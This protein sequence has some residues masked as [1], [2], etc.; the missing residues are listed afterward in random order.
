MNPAP[1]RVAQKRLFLIWGRERREVRSETLARHFGAKMFTISHPRLQ[2]P[3]LLPIKYLISAFQ[4]LWILLKERPRTVFVMNPPIFTGVVVWTFSLV[5]GSKFVIDTHSA[6][7]TRPA[8]RK[9]LP[10]YRFLARRASVNILHNSPLEDVV[11]SWGAKTLSLFFVPLDV[12]F[13]APFPFPPSKFRVA[14]V[15]SY[16]PDEP[17]DEVVQAAYSLPDM[18]F[19]VTGSTDLA[20]PALLDSA[21]PNVIFTDYL[22]RE[23]Y[24][25]LLAGADVVLSLTTE[26]DTMQCGAAEGLLLGRPILTSDTKV[27]R[28]FFHR[29]TVFTDNSSDGIVH[30]LELI[31]ADSGRLLR[32]V[33]ELRV[34]RLREWDSLSS[35]MDRVLGEID[36]ESLG[37]HNAS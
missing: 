24:L 9:L 15:S 26:D 11:R 6:A 10:V 27:L 14:V 25:S 3:L 19:Y 33:G 16:Y 8:W 37:A 34:E 17:L 4:T 35:E 12:R 20:P 7:F 32:E 31:R 28:D 23:D 29:G 2:T 18:T 21:P 5:S 30:A 36:T 1:A 13:S 22:A